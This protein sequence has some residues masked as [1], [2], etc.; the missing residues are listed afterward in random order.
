MPQIIKIDRGR[1]II[2]NLKK[3]TIFYLKLD[4][5]FKLDFLEN[6]VLNKKVFLFSSDLFLHHSFYIDHTTISQILCI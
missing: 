2:L 5:F 4:L 1:K 6:E 3:K